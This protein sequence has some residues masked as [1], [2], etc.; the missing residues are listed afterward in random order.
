MP[1]RP[2]QEVLEGEPF[3]G[4]ICGHQPFDQSSVLRRQGA[5]R[6]LSGRD[7]S[8][9]LRRYNRKRTYV[10]HETRV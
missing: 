10:S 7:G 3:D 6:A 1:V 8:A 9:L 5:R 2:A 4:G